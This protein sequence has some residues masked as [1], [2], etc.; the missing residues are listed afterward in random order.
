MEKKINVE[1]TLTRHEG[2]TYH[3]TYKNVQVDAGRQ[4][5]EFSTAWR[6]LVAPLIAEFEADAVAYKADDW[7]VVIGKRC[8]NTGK[9]IKIIKISESGLIDL[10]RYWN[11]PRDLRFATPAEI[12]AA[13]LTA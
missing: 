8:Y 7:V 5:A 13:Q 1:L 6:S 9:V 2:G 10:G 12:K 4:V 3:L 11:K